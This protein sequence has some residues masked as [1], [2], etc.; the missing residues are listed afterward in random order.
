MF[1][2]YIEEQW[3]P[4]ISM[5]DVYNNTPVYQEFSTNY[6]TTHTVRTEAY[7]PRVAFDKYY[8]NK[9]DKL[10]ALAEELEGKTPN[11]Q[12]F[13]IPKRTGGMRQIAAPDSDTSIYLNKIKLFLERDLHLLSH[14]AAY[15]YVKGRCTKDAL[16]QHTKHGSNFY[17]KIDLK[18][19]FPSCNAEFIFKQL[20]QL[21]II[22]SLQE[23]YFRALNEPL[24]TIINFCLLNGGLPQGSPVSPLLTNLIMIPLDY[25]ITSYCKLKGYC[26]TRYADDILISGKE[27]FDFKKVVKFLRGLLNYHTPFNVNN[28]KTRYGSNKGRN[29]NLGLMVNQ[30]NEITIGYRKK[31]RLR[32]TIYNFFNDLTNGNTWDIVDV[33]AFQGTL[34]YYHKISPKMTNEIVAKYNE[35]YNMNLFVEIQKIINE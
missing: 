9:G 15:A 31:E 13:S 11:Y 2:T 35:K 5:L 1:Y 27:D 28:D 12:L 16:L 4:T 32:A 18:D 8:K 26:Y 19:F 33:Q 30:K 34:S 21:Q 3:R 24:K 14:N 17:L 10:I 23:E 20:H 22:A 25:Y 6:T 7:M 29:W